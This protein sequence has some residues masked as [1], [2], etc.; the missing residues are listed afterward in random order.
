MGGFNSSGASSSES[1][2]STLLT[3]SL[4]N[5]SGSAPAVRDGSEIG[6]RGTVIGTKGSTEG[7]ITFARDPIDNTATPISTNPHGEVRVSSTSLEDILKELLVI[8]RVNMFLLAKI[9]DVQLSNHRDMTAISEEFE[10]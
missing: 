3:G 6:L 5:A 7:Y 1:A 2:T 4:V 10:D 8:Q 9:A